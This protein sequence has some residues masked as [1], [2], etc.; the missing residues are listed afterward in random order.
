MRYLAGSF[1]T[2]KQD[3]RLH[4]LEAAGLSAAQIAE[5]LGITRNA[6]LGRSHRLRGLVF[7][8][9][10]RREQNLRALSAAR[11]REMKRRSAA[12]LSAMREA[13]A[14]GTPRKFAII[15]AVEAGVTYQAIGHELGISRQRVHQIVSSE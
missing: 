11:R 14:Q 12:M 8:S 15:E 1:W 9:E 7:R 3:S 4:K 13:I 10:I 2:L 5:R 6:V